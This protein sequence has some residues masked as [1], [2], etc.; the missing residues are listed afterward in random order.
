VLPEAHARPQAPQLPWSVVRSEQAEAQ[1]VV[2]GGQAH[3]PPP[4]TA[5]GTQGFSQA[6]Q[7]P[8]LPSVFV[9]HPSLC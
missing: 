7:C 1:S 8:A 4:Q 2:S 5:P 3:T 6:P 9:S